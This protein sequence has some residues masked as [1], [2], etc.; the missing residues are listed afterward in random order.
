LLNMSERHIFSQPTQC[1]ARLHLDDL[2]AWLGV[3]GLTAALRV[4]GLLAA[5]D[6]HAAAVRDAVAAAGR[7]LAAPALAGYA[8]SVTAAAHRMGSTVPDR[9]PDGTVDWYR[10]GWHTLRL[11][12]VCALADEAGLL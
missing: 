8:R 12:A 2:M 10:P 5:V 3:D 4:P 9:E 11:I 7:E 6:Q 1:P